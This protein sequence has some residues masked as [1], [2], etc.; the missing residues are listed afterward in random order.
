MTE[1][2]TGRRHTFVKNV[3]QFVCTHPLQEADLP[4]RPLE[5]ERTAHP[6]LQP[7]GAWKQGRRQPT[8]LYASARGHVSRHELREGT[9]RDRRRTLH[10]RGL[11]PTPIIREK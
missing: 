6:D 8:P 7:E 9:A 2:V 11:L 3:T 5:A 1:C 4:I 10:P